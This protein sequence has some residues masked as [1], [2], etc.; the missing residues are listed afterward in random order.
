MNLF[1]IILLSI[2]VSLGVFKITM[3]A[4]IESCLDAMERLK[5]AF[6]F[7]LFKS[8]LMLLGFWITSLFAHMVWD[9]RFTLIVSIFIVLGLKILFEIV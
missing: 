7:A 9:M 2:A 3:E 1:E 4:A 6:V 8:G 5:I